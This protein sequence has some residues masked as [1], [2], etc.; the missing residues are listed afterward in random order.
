MSYGPPLKVERTEKRWPLFAI[1]R[2]H[3]IVK[4]ILLYF[5]KHYSE[6]DNEY[7]INQKFYGAEWLEEIE[8]GN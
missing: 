4:A 3:L 5:I 6:E 1:E 7:P 2:K 8:N